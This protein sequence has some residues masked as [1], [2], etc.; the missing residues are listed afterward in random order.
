MLLCGFVEDEFLVVVAFARRK[1]ASFLDFELKDFFDDF[2]L[3]ECGELCVIGVVFICVYGLFIGELLFVLELFM[4]V[5]LVC[6]GED[7]CFGA[8]DGA[9][10]VWNIVIGECVFK[11]LFVVLVSGEFI[12]D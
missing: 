1:R 6:A 8:R 9:F 5:L 4:V 2:L 12:D 7:A 3:S 10:V 11:V